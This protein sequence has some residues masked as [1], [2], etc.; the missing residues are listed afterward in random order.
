[1]FKRL[2]TT[3]E[4]VRLLLLADPA[5]WSAQLVAAREEVDRELGDGDTKDFLSRVISVV[6]AATGE[7]SEVVR[8]LSVLH[9]G[10]RSMLSSVLEGD[11]QDKAIE[12]LDESM[13]REDTRQALAYVRAHA[14]ATM[15]R[16]SSNMEDLMNPNPEGGAYVEIRGLSRDEVKA[17]ERECGV[18]PRL[19]GLLSSKALDAARKAARVGEDSTEAYTRYIAKLEPEE[20][21]AIQAFEDWNDSLEREIFKRAVHS[22]DGFDLV[23]DGYGFPVDEFRKQCEEAQEVITEAARHARQV[24]SLDPKVEPSLSSRSG[25]E[26]SSDGDQEP[27]TAGSAPTA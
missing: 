14:C 8:A 7:H 22:I 11:A 18:R 17:A 4:P 26:G 10:A 23:R 21:I 15:Y 25:T 20:Q 19:G 2:T 3:T 6:R 1:M 5:V 12:N 24:G 9:E 27:G 13:K 16:E